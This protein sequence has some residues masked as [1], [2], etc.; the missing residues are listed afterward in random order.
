MNNKHL[1]RGF[2]LIE[3]LVVVLIIGILAAVALPQYQQ[4]V[5]KSRAAEA[6]INARAIR[7]AIDRHMME[8]PDDLVS[9]FDQI[10]DVKLK[11]DMYNDHVFMTPYASSSGGTK[12]IY[13]LT[14]QNSFYACRAGNTDDCGP[15]TITYT[16]SNNGSWNIAATSCE[17]DYEQVCRLFTNI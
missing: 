5:E 17:A 13:V 8:F 16:R 4:A 6:L 9:R 11:G 7:D 3:L 14:G 12:F 2:T 10:A 15:Y 1:K